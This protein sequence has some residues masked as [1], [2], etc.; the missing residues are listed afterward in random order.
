MYSI[1]IVLCHCVPFRVYCSVNL[2]D[3]PDVISITTYLAVG[4]TV[5]TLYSLV[6]AALYQ[7]AKEVQCVLLAILYVGVYVCT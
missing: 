5:T 6:L 2:S 3:P 1:G 7:R 4:Q